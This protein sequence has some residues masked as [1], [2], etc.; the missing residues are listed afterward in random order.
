MCLPSHEPPV[1]VTIARASAS[2]DFPLLNRAA[3]RQ[4]SKLE[5]PLDEI[6]AAV[7]VVWR[8][9]SPNTSTSGTKKA[10]DLVGRSSGSPVHFPRLHV[11][12]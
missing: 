7:P 2:S 12:D 8:E 11:D 3:S 9:F 5:Q 1:A 6:V 10:G 4:V